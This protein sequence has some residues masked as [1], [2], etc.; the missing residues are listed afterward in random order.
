MLKL[1]NGVCRILNQNHEES[2]TQDGMDIAL[3]LIDKKDKKI[4]F[5]GANRPLYL[6]KNG[7]IEV[8]KGNRFGIGGI[9]T[10][11]LKKYTSHKILVEPGDAIYLTTDGY[12]DQFGE[13]KKC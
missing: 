12:S 9:Q 10:E 4:E 2:T 3:C 13:I 7:I 8:I 5:A 6:F 1:N 11:S